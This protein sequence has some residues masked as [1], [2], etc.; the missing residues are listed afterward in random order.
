MDYTSVHNPRYQRAETRESNWIREV[1][2]QKK[3]E[4]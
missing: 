3:S 1:K 2:I 4:I